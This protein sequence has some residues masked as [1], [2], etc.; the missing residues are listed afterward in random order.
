MPGPD[1]A[2]EL[3]LLNTQNNYTALVVDTT[4]ALNFQQGTMVYWHPANPESQFF[5]NDRDPETGKV[6]R[7]LYD[8]NMGKRI[9]EYRFEDTPIRKGG[10][11]PDG[12]YFAG[13]NYAR[14]ARL[15]P[16]TGYPGAHDWTTGVSTPADDGVF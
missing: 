7:V 12:Q 9:H 13:I 11:S 3:I 16:V 4:R 8:I 6:F 1:E 10:V 15:R 14:L 5:F 2:A